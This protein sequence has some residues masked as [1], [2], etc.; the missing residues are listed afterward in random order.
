MGQCYSIDAFLSFVDLIVCLYLHTQRMHACNAKG[1][2]ESNVSLFVCVWLPA[3]AHAEASI[4]CIL[5]SAYILC[6]AQQKS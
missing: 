4:Y 3:Y 5:A 2:S 1:K 6:S